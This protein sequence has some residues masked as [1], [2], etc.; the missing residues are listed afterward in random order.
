MPEALATGDISADYAAIADASG[1]LSTECT[2]IH[3][4]VIDLHTEVSTLL[5]TALFWRRASPALKTAYTEFSK[6]VQSGAA[7]LQ[8]WAAVLTAISDG[9]KNSDETLF[10]SA[11]SSIDGEGGYELDP[12]P[13][14]ETPVDDPPTWDPP[15]NGGTPIAYSEDGETYLGPTSQ[16]A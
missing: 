6:T 10:A 12:G 13:P 3:Q 16:L 9:F 15:N 4:K 5:D 11:L 7:Q 2:T 8:S 1:K 14:I